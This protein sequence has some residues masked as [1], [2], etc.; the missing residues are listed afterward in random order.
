MTELLLVEDEEHIVSGLIFNLEME[1]YKVTHAKDGNIAK[2]ILFDDN[3]R[4][5]LI[6]LDI[7]LPGI[8]GFELCHALRK[9]KDFTPVLMLTAKKFDKDKINGLQI[10][11]D[12]YITKPFNLEELLTRIQVLLRRQD[13]LKQDK[14]E[15][16]LKFRDVIIDFDSFTAFVSD[17]PIKMTNLEFKLIKVLSDNEGKVLS[18][19]ELFEKVWDIKDYLNL[20]TVDNFIMRLRKYF[21]IDP[22]NPKHFHS[23][24]GVGYKFTIEESF[25]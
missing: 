4:F 10:G 2:K 12:D 14:K 13:W 23:F 18:R 19:E 1:G 21:E 20:R 8:G 17:N 15:N 25:I 11:A 7:M 6:I 24:R 22:S 3:K 16:I 9:K 5:D